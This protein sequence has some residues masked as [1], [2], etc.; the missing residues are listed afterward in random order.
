MRSGSRLVT[1]L[2]SSLLA[3]STHAF[4]QSATTSLRGTISDAKGAVVSSA[5][6]TLTNQATAYSRTVKTDGQGSYQFLEVPP[7]T[8]VMTVTASGFA[9]TKRENVVLQ[10]SSQATVNLTLEIQRGSV[11]VD[12]TG[13]A[14]AV[15]TTDATLGNNFNARQLTDLPSE[16]RDPAAILSLQPGVVYIG[17]AANQGIIPNQQ[18]NDSRG[19]AVNGA[20]S[21]QSNVTL[22][23]LD[24]NDQLEGY[25]FR[26]A[27]RATLDSLQEFRVTTS[28]YDAAS[29]RSSGAQVNLV[30]KS[31]T[32]AFHGSVY[33]YHRPTFDVANDWFNKKSELIQGK[34]N[35]PQ[36]ILRNTFGGTVGGPLKKDRLFFFG[37]YE[38]QRTADQVPTNRVIPTQ[39]LDQGFIKY[40]CN[41]S[42]DPNCSTTN[43][44]VN[45]VSNPSFSPLLVATLTPA[46][47]AS[48]DQGCGANGTCPLGPGVN[49]LIANI[50]GTNP[51]ALF[52]HYPAPNCPSCGNASQGSGDLLNSSGFTFPG[53]DPTKLDTYIFRSEEHTSEL[54]SH[55]N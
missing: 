28:N 38:G 18:N 1:V 50:G 6:V 15:N 44:T 49:P 8:Y 3:L 30:T 36:H 10:V 31:G 43:P 23:G 51:N 12:V 55:V 11:I 45:V 7:S 32:N 25:A 34:P 16:G 20:R 35:I 17:S 22:D 2:I 54:Q 19:G 40:L 21:D 48:L 14:P 13:E 39:S 53:N 9:T 29:G 47:F 41:P 26:G 33:E 46:Q 42:S 52:T 24:D 5:T 4:A 37:A 27:M